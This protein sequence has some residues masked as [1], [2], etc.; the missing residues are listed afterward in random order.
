M[1]AATKKIWTWIKEEI[2]RKDSYYRLKVIHI[3]TPSLREVPEDIPNLANH[4]LIKY[5]QFMQTELK[6]FTPGA[7]QSLLGYPW[8][9]NARQLENEVK[10]LV[11]SVRRKSITE[12][13]LDPSI[14]NPG[15]PIQNVQPKEEP[16][17]KST[18]SRSLPDAVE[19]LE[20]GSSKKQCE[21][22]VET[23]KRRL[24]C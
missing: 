7:L 3:H 16:T 8:P 2:F 23:N 17:P 14:R 20:R 6:Q 11:A 15:A 21:T 9:G 5:C 12:D 18:A 19:Q 13:H 1:T 10:R 22:L 4:F 24:R